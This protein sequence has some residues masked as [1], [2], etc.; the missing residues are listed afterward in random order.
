MDADQF[1]LHPLSDQARTGAR[2][3]S[4]AWA[5]EHSIKQILRYRLPGLRIALFKENR[6]S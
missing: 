5:N 4:T 1:S 6:C 3:R 2:R